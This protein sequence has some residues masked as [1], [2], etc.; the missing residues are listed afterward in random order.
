MACLTKCDDKLA[1]EGQTSKLE[2]EREREREREKRKRGEREIFLERNV[3]RNEENT[4]L[5]YFIFTNRVIFKF[6]DRKRDV[7]L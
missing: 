2:G 3:R 7:F 1:K 4:Q 5:P 6:T